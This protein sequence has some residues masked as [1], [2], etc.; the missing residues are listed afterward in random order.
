MGAQSLETIKGNIKD[1]LFHGLSCN[2]DYVNDWAFTTVFVNIIG[3]PHLVHLSVNT[4]YRLLDVPSRM[5]SARG[6]M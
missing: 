4:Y 5:I 3:S 1:D 6:R 2:A